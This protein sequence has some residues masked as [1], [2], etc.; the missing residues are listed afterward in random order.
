MNHAVILTR[1]A[2]KH[3][4]TVEYRTSGITDDLCAGYLFMPLGFGKSHFRKAVNHK[5]SVITPRDNI[6][7]VN[8][9]RTDAPVHILQLL[10]CP[11]VTQREP[12]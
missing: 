7:R 10:Y 2:G 5:F 4:R 1:A 11:A 6:L 3:V 8:R 12:V 9:V